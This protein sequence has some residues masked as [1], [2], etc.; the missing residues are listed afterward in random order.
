MSAREQI[1][2]VEAQIDVKPS[3][4]LSDEQIAEAPILVLG[5]KI[6]KPGASPSMRG[7]PGWSEPLQQRGCLCSPFALRPLHL[8]CSPH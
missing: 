5:N 1:S 8:Q 6:D 2:G 4:G 7:E 3:Y